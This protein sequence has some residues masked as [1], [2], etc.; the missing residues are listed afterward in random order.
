LDVRNDYDDDDDVLFYELI[1]VKI[2]D[3]YGD[4]V[5]DVYGDDVCDVFFL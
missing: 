3:V 4:D 1:Y 2:H 5:Y